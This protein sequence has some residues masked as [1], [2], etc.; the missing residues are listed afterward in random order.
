M[1]V[2]GKMEEG[3]PRQTNPDMGCSGIFQD[4]YC[5]IYHRQVTS[6]KCVCIT[7]MGNHLRNTKIMIN[8]IILYKR[9]NRTRYL[10]LKQKIKC[11][12]HPAP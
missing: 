3:P 5:R 9:Y 8:D 11:H 10:H 7:D 12:N 6:E 1:E 4:K 2:S